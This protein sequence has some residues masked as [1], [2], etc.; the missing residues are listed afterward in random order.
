MVESISMKTKLILALFMSL[1]FYPLFSQS[2][3]MQGYNCRRTGNSPNP[4]PIIPEVKWYFD[5]ARL[6][7]NASPIVGSD[8]IVYQITENALINDG[9]K[10]IKPDG[11]L[12]WTSSCTG[13]AAAALSPNG[14]QIYATS[15]IFG[16]VVAL[17]T[18]NGSQIWKYEFPGDL[19]YSSLAVDDNGIIYFGTRSPASL[20][21]LNP[22]GILK[23]KYTHPNSDY[24]GI[25]APPAIGPDGSVYCIINTIGLVTLD[26]NG[27]FKWS[28]GE[29]CGDYG[30]PT[31]CVL[32]D[33]TI[34][35]AGSES[36]GMYGYDK[37][38]AFN[39]DGTK[40]WQRGDIGEQHGYFPGVAVSN[41]EST[42]F[43]AR[44]GG[45]M[46]ALNAQTGE[47]KWSNK[48]SSYELDGS[49]ILASNG[50]IYV[51]SDADYVFAILEL[52]GS[53]LWQYQLNA[54]ALYWGPP[55]PALGPDG[56]LYV[57][58]CGTVPALENIPGRIYAFKYTPFKAP[59]VSITQPL[60]NSTFT[61]DDSIQI[62]VLASNGD[63]IVQKVEFF[64]NSVKLGE[65]T[66]RTDGFSYSWK[67]ILVGSFELSSIA[68][69]DHKIKSISLPIKINVVPSGPTLIP[70]TKTFETLPTSLL[71]Y[72]NPTN[73]VIYIEQ[74]EN[75]S[76]SGNIEVIDILG[77]IMFHRNWDE[78][79][80]QELNLT[81][82]SKGIYLLRIRNKNNNYFQ[83][84]VI[85]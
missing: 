26:K 17:N 25:E 8:S 71:V 65:D 78:S 66:I 55:S 85:R 15:S 61:S 33:G 49:P 23:W 58:A 50:I 41:D 64:S 18:Q 76:V 11:S 46:Y 80:R 75:L 74:K 13:R 45:M 84:V 40:K 6:Q 63:G 59:T 30:W 53:L 31:P 47:T 16:D 12:K 60:N 67:N 43:L 77:R 29:N 27:N 14:A 20:Y 81:N 70:P 21:A 1:Y 37:I 10:A 24:I 7:D 72:P 35:I 73:G 52:D 51:M 69:D 42:I 32:S 28:N 56:T 68:T 83:K 19:S 38:I 36:H 22:D 54:S 4:G 5:M 2:W 9:L 34:I 57:T 44:S 62:V 3:P 48:I 39:P 82:L 79:T